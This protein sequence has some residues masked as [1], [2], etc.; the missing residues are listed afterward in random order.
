MI[1]RYVFGALFAGVVGLWLAACESQMPAAGGEDLPLVR[2]G[3]EVIRTGDF[4]RFVAKLPE[5]T[6]SE[7]AGGEKVRDYL[8]TLVDRALI[9]RAAADGGL[10]QS[11]Q[12]ED[13][14][15]WALEQ[16]LVQEVEGREIKRDIAVDEAEVRA[17]YAERGWGRRLKVAHIYVRTDGALDT[18]MAELRSGKAFGEVARLYSQ[19]PPS[20]EHDGEK[21]YYYSRNNA[22]PEVRDAL[23]RLKVGER[24]E[25]LPIPKGYEIFLVLD[26]VEA[27]FEEIAE[28]VGQEL[29]QERL[30]AVR[31]EYF[32][33]FEKRLGLRPEPQG[34][35]TLMGAL[36]RSED[37][38]VFRYSDREM[39]VPLFS[40]DRGDITFG[41]ALARSSFLRR[42]RGFDD[43]LRVVGAVKREVVWARLLALRGR[44]LGIDQEPEIRAWLERK[45]EEI[46]I[47]QMRQSMAVRTVAVADG[48]VRQYYEENKRFYRTARKVEVVEVQ[49]P[50]QS[51]AEAVLDEV[52]RDLGAAGE[53]IALVGRIEEK[54]EA[55]QAVGAEMQALG[56]LEGESGVY[57]WLGERLGRDADRVA[58][59]EE[60]AGSSSAKDLVQTYIVQYMALTRSTRPGDGRLQLH[61]IDAT[62]LG[63]L[64]DAAMEAEVGDFI[65]PAEYEGL[66]SVAKVVAHDEPQIRPFAEVERGI[67]SKLHSRKVDEAFDRWLVELRA[68]YEGEVEFIT[69]NIAALAAQ[70]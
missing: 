70:N 44:E 39:G 65:G 43:S 27:P 5:W 16:R 57:E 35:G 50:S 6:K 67:R 23:F 31:Q 24:S 69:E 58:L 28:K 54:L 7:Q 45:R 17:A 49:L 62:R 15:E 10:A 18:V 56:R 32:D 8:Q 37:G 55:E 51:E 47:R 26:E 9:L 30:S 48:Q 2:I 60:I 40:Y 66:Y 52:E 53:L 42:G 3:D 11:P 38:K 19:D 46:L 34:L 1:F 13:A 41:E 59:L 63:P 22:T 21:P 29:L 20:A 61:R 36:R 14:L 4:E 12:V 25:P 64:V 68:A 33:A